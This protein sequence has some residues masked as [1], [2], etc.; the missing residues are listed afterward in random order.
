MIKKTQLDS[1]HAKW[2]NKRQQSKPF[3]T[4]GGDPR[5]NLETRL[6]SSNNDEYGYGYG[7]VWISLS[8]AE[9]LVSSLIP[10]TSKNNKNDDD[11]NN[12]NNN[13]GKSTV[14]SSIFE[15]NYFYNNGNNMTA[16]TSSKQPMTMMR[17]E[18]HVAV[19]R[20]PIFLYGYYTKSRRDVSQTPFVVMREKTTI[21]KTKDIA[22]DN[23]VSSNKKQAERL[24]VTLV[25]KQICNPI[26]NL[27]GV[28]TL[29]NVTP[30]R[31][32]N[33]SDGGGGGGV[34][35][36]GVLYGMIKL[37][38]SSREDMDVRMLV[39][40]K[41]SSKTDP[42]SMEETTTSSCHGR[43]F[44]VQ[45]VDAL[46]PIISSKQLR[47]LINNINHT[48]TRTTTT[49]TITDLVA[50]SNDNAILYGQN[51]MG[52]GISPDT[53]KPVAATIFSGL[54]KDTE[55]KTKN[56][57]CYCWSKN[58]LPH[59]GNENDNTITSFIFH[60]RRVPGRCAS[61]DNARDTSR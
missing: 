32:D 17:M 28:S 15:V 46:R 47:D 51:P 50:N 1:D 3:I 21:E 26:E 18:Y 35:G 25:E 27:L 13:S 57:G 42:D 31:S 44:C 61:I 22:N 7:Y 23:G 45:I 5:A 37:Y 20:R 4:Q 16:T 29:N 49:I 39:R 41:W 38:A 8:T 59:N 10:L 24:G 40:R 14:M 52:V 19:F 2:C 58:I 6:Q 11:D 9:E 34:G 56:Y 33:T 54:Q 48:T 53:F 55:S 43:P 60:N 12:N 36:G 30:S